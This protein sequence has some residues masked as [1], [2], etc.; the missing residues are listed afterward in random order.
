MALQVISAGAAKG[1]VDA[2]R[3][4]FLH[5]TNATIDGTFGAVGAMKEKLLSGAPCDA[6]IL[7][8]ALLEALSQDGHVRGDTIA[9][10]GHVHTGVAVRSRD[11][12]VPIDSPGALRESLRAATSI[13]VPDPERST[14]GIHFMRVLDRLGIRD[15][16]ASRLRAFPNGATAMAALAV[17]SDAR[18]IGCTQIT[19]ILYTPDVRLVG[20]LPKAFELAT[21]YSAAVA[22]GATEPALAAR[23]VALVTGPEGVR[24]RRSGGFE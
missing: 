19:E 1:L 9:P 18:P 5:D 7:T 23:L 2:L 6:V 10:I 11:A 22:S 12:V 17:A 13:H 15:E 20:K 3:E 16:L 21:L 24:L 8:Q 4:R 14:A